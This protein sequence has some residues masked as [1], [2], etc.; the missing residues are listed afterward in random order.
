MKSILTLI[1]ASLMTLASFGQDIIEITFDSFDEDPLYTPADT[2]IS[3]RTGETIITP[4]NWLVKLEHDTYR[5]SFNFYG[6]DL[7]GTY[8]FT[9]GD[10]L[11]DYTY[12]YDKQTTPYAT[13]IDFESCEFT[14]TETRPSATI[15]RY[16][17]EA[18]IVDTNDKHYLVKATHDIL[19]ATE[20]VEAEI[21]DAQITPTEYGFVLTAKDT[22]EDLDIQLA[23][24][25]NFGITGSFTS[26]LVN[27]ELTAITHNGT[28]FDPQELEM[29]ITFAE[30]LSTGKPGYI[31]PSLQFLSPDVVAY[32]LHL[33]APIIATDTVEITCFNLAWDESQKSESA[34]MFEA[35]N[36]TYAV[37]GMLSAESIKAGEYIG[38]K[39]SLELTEI[40]TGASITPLTSTLTVAGNKLKGFTV[41]AE[42]LGN[43]HK[44]Y[45]LDLSLQNETPSNVD[46]VEVKKE[47]QKMIVNG[48]LIIMKDGAKYNSMGQMIK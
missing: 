12:G 4:A 7:V 48:Q 1:F 23:I 17:L 15:T 19:T 39:A 3:R 11:E 42:V 8:S 22:D 6:E 32:N 10:F 36:G 43:D 40:A 5:F 44:V 31:I 34:I 35:S 20:V 13:R 47:T 45:N 37:F 46:N 2:T 21:P 18:N 30:N 9:E 28:T 16:I 33:E 38:E 14:I 24:E 41:E 27:Q 26:K 25:W 29:T